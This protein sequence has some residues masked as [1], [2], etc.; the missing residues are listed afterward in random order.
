MKSRVVTNV[1]DFKDAGGNWVRSYSPEPAVRHVTRAEVIWNSISKRSKIGGF[2][3]NRNQTYVGVTNDFQ[4]FQEL[5]E[6]CQSQY[7]Y[8]NTEVNGNYWSIDKDL[9]LPSNKSYS[10]ETCVFVP[11]RVNALMLKRSIRVNKHPLGVCLPAKS[12]QFQSRCH[13]GS[14]GSNYL[15]YFDCELEAHQAWQ[16][17]KIDLIR[18][19]IV[20]DEEIRNHLEL[21]PI[22]LAQAQRIEDDL[23]AGVETK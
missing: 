13:D 22:L 17:Y 10:A 14:G 8:L 12:K 5:A 19:I 6:W 3:Q 18:R 1:E 11:H 4:D 9:K 23:L 2:E 7:G 15:G 20:E 16:R 21:V